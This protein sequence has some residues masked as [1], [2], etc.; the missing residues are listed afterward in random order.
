MNMA[1]TGE[2]ADPKRGPGTRPHFFEPRL[3][4]RKASNSSS[5]VARARWWNAS[6]RPQEHE[7]SYR[8][9]GELEWP[10]PQDESDSPPVDRDSCYMADWT[11]L[12][13]SRRDPE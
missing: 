1:E 3:K 4:M 6:K 8:Y 13:A 7:R 5:L 2:G 9:L 10:D 12:P 11:E